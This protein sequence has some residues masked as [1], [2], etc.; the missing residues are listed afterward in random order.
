MAAE[1]DR[2]AEGYQAYLD[3]YPQGRYAV[4]ARIKLKGLQ[5]PATPAAAPQAPTSEA[6]AAPGA[7][8]ALTTIGKTWLGQLDAAIARRDATAI[9]AVFAP[10]AAV[11]ATVRGADGKMTPVD[12]RREEF[13]RSTIVAMKGLED[14]KQRR[15]WTEGKAVDPA[16]GAACDRISLRSLVVEQGRQSRKPYRFE[17][18]EEYVLELRAGKWLAVKAETTQQ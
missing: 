17:S 16:S 9:I 14:Y 3:A 5:K 11:R 15:V 10:E 6:A 2:T 8:C 4:A 12:I 1:N 13:V 18:L 7:E